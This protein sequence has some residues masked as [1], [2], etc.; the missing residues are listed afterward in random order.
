MGY[1]DEISAFLTRHEVSNQP[2]EDGILVPDER[3]VIQCI[4]TTNHNEKKEWSKYYRS[5]CEARG[6]R[7]IVIPDFYWT[8]AKDA[9]K[10]RLHVTFHTG[11]R[12]HADQTRIMPLSETTAMRFL[13]QYHV[14][15]FP[16]EREDGYD[17]YE[18]MIHYSLITKKTSEIVAVMTFAA[19]DI[20]FHGHEL[21]RYATRGT[22]IGGA[23]RLFN[24]YVSVYQPD[25]V[26][27]D[28]DLNWETGGVF[29]FMG[30]KS[31]SFVEPEGHYVSGWHKF[32]WEPEKG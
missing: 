24:S 28:C 30:F 31:Y 16:I 13:D 29:Y 7:L 11:G 19:D 4:D 17:P 8:R 5:C 25:A 3:I 1:I 32:I 21:L 22:V 27:A 15:G 18:N 23:R 26:Y 20:C 10:R 12:I 9:V 2:F 14:D 6:Y